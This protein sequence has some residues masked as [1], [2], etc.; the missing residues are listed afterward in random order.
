MNHS[1][2]LVSTIVSRTQTLPHRDFVS[3]F[4]NGVFRRDWPCRFALQTSRTIC[5][6]QLDLSPKRKKPD[7]TRFSENVKGV[8]ELFSGRQNTKKSHLYR[9]LICQGCKNEISSLYYSSISISGIISASVS[10]RVGCWSFLIARISIWR[11]RSRVKA[12]KRPTS[13]SVYKCPLARP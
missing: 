10:K 2:N 3:P 12:K 11:T 13:S 5:R 8:V 9:W 7:Y 1:L 6:A 4:F